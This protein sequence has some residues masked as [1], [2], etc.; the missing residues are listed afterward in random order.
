MEAIARDTDH[1][2]LPAA[3]IAIG[4]VDAD[5]AA[6]QPAYTHMQAC[7]RSLRQQLWRILTEYGVGETKAIREKV[8]GV[9]RP[10]LWG[11]CLMPTIQIGRA[12]IAYELR[13]S[14]TAAERRITVTPGHVEVMA[15]TSDN[16]DDIAGFLVRRQMIEAVRFIPIEREWVVE[17]A[18]QST[19]LCSARTNPSYR[20]K[21]YQD[22]PAAGCVC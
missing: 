17:A 20:A 1:A 8:D 14:A 19:S 7:L 16:D 22:R 18:I 5:A 4:A 15:L 21:F 9:R 12:E 6:A 13:R 10:R 11:G 3:A 2:T